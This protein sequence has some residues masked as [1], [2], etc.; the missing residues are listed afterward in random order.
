MF[1]LIYLLLLSTIANANNSFVGKGKVLELT[2]AP[3][4]VFIVHLA[5]KNQCRKEGYHLKLNEKESKVYIDML[6]KAM[7]RQWSVALHSSTGAN[8]NAKKVFF[9][10][11]KIQSY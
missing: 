10:I 3:G 1:A 6:M 4:N 2:I 8:C 5:G 11:V 9:D 7:E